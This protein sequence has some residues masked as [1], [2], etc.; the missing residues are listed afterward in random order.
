MPFHGRKP[1]KPIKAMRARR[2]NNPHRKDTPRSQSALSKA[3]SS[4][5]LRSA[6]ILRVGL[7]RGEQHR[8]PNNLGGR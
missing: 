4:N 7:S 1:A 5:N 8:P 2:A 3:S 6:Q